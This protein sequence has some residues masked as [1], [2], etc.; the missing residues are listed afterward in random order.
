MIIHNSGC[1]RC[2]G[3]LLTCSAPRG[4]AGFVKCFPLG[5][6]LTVS[7]PALAARASAL[8]AHRCVALGVPHPHT[9][10]RRAPLCVCFA[11]LHGVLGSSKGGMREPKQPLD[12]ADGE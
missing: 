11:G 6:R 1:I 2:L 5:N 8:A 12:C 3:C 4:P 7:R 10:L 9:D